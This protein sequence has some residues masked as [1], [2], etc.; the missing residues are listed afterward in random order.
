MPVNF[1]VFQCRKDHKFVWTD[2]CE[3]AFKALKQALVTAPILAFPNFQE[4]FHLYTDTSSEGIGATLGQIQNN[5]EVAKLMPVEILITPKETIA[6]PN[7][8]HQSS[9]SA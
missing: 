3:E 9:F 1:Q 2:S 6:Q 7:G 8:K 4:T 5:K